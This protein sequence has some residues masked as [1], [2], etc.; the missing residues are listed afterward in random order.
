MAE[1]MRVLIVLQRVVTVVP[2]FLIDGKR[3]EGMPSAEGLN[4]LLNGAAVVRY[5]VRGCRRGSA[6]LCVRL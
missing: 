4:R 6:R 2:T 5:G 1:W 3:L